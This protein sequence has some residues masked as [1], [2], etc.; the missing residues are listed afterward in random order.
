MRPNT[1]FPAC[2]RNQ[3][4][5]VSMGEICIIHTMLSQTSQAVPHCPMLTQ[6]VPCWPKLSH[7]PMLTQAVP[8]CPMLTQAVPCWPRL[9][10]TVPCCPRLSHAVPDCSVANVAAWLTTKT[11]V[12]SQFLLK[13]SNSPKLT[14]TILLAQFMIL[15]FNINRVLA[16][17]LWLQFTFSN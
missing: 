16:L 15:Y 14:S 4:W 1:F 11:L 10:Q 6:T 7:S 12:V 3:T 5:A 17:T 2:T 13:S 8:H 9:S